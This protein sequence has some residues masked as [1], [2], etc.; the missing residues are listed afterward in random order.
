MIIFQALYFALPLYLANMAPV[1]MKWLP[2]LD[3]PIDGGATY[4]GQR[5]LGKGKTWRG[6]VFAVIFAL[7][8]IAVQKY[9]YVS[10]VFFQELSLFDYGRSDVWLLG[11]LLGLGAIGGDALKSFFKRRRG[12]K[13]GGAWPPFDQLD[14]IIGGLL[15]GS[16]VYWPGLEAV[17]IIAI[18]SPFLHWLTNFISF[19]LGIKDVPW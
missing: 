9:L 1:I 17:L 7:V 10:N 11:I 15:L 12:I 3:A 5:V 14:F 8:A 13:S 19:K 18:I 2:F 6:L 4:K 16:I